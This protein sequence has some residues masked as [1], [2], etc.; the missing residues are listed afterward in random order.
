MDDPFK[1]LGLKPG[2]SLKTALKKRNALYLVLH[3]DKNPSDKTK[4]Q[5]VYD[6]YDKLIKN[7]KL[8]DLPIIPTGKIEQ[9]TRVRHSVTIRDFYFKKPQT[10]T[11]KRKIFCRTC[12]GS[13]SA[14]GDKGHCPQCEGTGKIVSSILSLLGKDSTCPICHGTGLKTEVLC[15]TCEGHR[16]LQETSSI[17]F[18]LEPINFHKKIA[19]LYNVGDQISSNSFGTVAVALKIPHLDSITIEENY[20]VVYDTVSPVQKI[21]GDTK[22]MKVLGREITYQ[23]PENSTEV[24]FIDV[25]SPDVSQELR[26]KFIDIP[27]VLTR[28]TVCLY[29]KIL[30]IEKNYETNDGFIQF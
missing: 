5:K 22:T 16:Y 12:G 30:E 7:P 17:Q 26:I 20:F 21:I 4:F 28:E 23:I 9:I 11:I 27:P 18:I 25:I 8:L 29:K 13:G 10:I 3:P 1:I 14:I 15:K 2:D 24:Y 6:A 19:V